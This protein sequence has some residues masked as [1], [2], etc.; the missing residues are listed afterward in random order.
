MSDS[1]NIK[2]KRNLSALVEFSK[3]IN[4]SLDLDFILNNV[5]LTCMGKFL[6]TKGFIAIGIEGKFVLKSFK[7]P[8]GNLGK[9]FPEISVYE[10]IVDNAELKEFIEENK[11]AVTEKINSSDGCIGFICLGE[12]LNKSAF[13]DDDKEFL[14]TILNISA[15]AVQNSIVVDELKRVN[16]VLD[17]RIQSLSSLFE[18]SKEFGLLNDSSAVVKLLVYSVIGQFLVS[19]F[20]VV[21][22][23]DGINIIETKFPESELHKALKGCKCTE[24][25]NPVG[26]NEI[27]QNYKSLHDL[28]IELIVPMQLQ[29]KTKGAV[30]LGKRINNKNFSG[31][32]VE[33]ISSVGS[34]AI[35]ALENIHLFKETLAKQKMEEELELARGIQRNLLPDS[36]PQ[37]LRFDIAANS[38]TSQQVGGDY[39]DLIKLDD[40]SF[41]V[42]IGDV[43]G[44]G[45]PAALLMANLQA[46]LKTTVKRG[47]N[48]SEATE[49]INDLISENTSDGKFITFFWGVLNESDLTF[50]Y[51]NAG[52]NPPLLIRNGKITKLTKGG[53][54]LGV[55]KTAFPY[56]SETVQL[57]KDDVIVMFTDGITEA[58]NIKD[59]EFSDESLEKLVVSCADESAGIILDTV[60]KEVQA[61]AAG[62]TQSDDITL[63][64]I[65]VK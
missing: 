15:S 37:L 29:G 64:V 65:K 55:M 5:L 1:E 57:E 59:E 18:L 56:E 40:E 4:S 14:R 39:Y 49:L 30:L 26:K 36:V 43:S 12:K 9:N 21:I 54:I 23:N 62:I 27:D 22:F 45:V 35:V 61:F 42:A 3:I 2:V 48:L 44:K 24:L 10:N 41:C 46:F 17:L 52:H 50:Y 13:T 32:D 25:Q 7:G 53:L 28:K 58:K 8:D 20:A 60:K 34:L 47:M 31:Q 16:R 11:I 33:F 51:V 38:L 63:V 19:K 6:T